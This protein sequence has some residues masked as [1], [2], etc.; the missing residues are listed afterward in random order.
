MA[1]AV[2]LGLAVALTGCSVSS[3][4][5]AAQGFMEGSQWTPAA[6]PVA[7]TWDELPGCPGALEGEVDVWTRV[8]GFPEQQIDAVGI[9][10]ECGDTWVDQPDGDNFVSIVATVRDTDVY[11]LDS[12]LTLAGYALEWD[13]FTTPTDTTIEGY[14][15][16]RDYY[17]ADGETVFTI[18][19]Y[20]APFVS[21]LY[22]V[23]LD[24]H[25]PATR[26][27]GGSPAGDLGL[28]TGPTSGRAAHSDSADKWVPD[29]DGDAGSSVSGFVPVTVK[30]PVDW[31]HLAPC[32]DGSGGTAWV[33]VSSFPSEIV[34]ESGI[35][36]FCGDTFVTDDGDSFVS[37]VATITEEQIYSLGGKLIAAGYT[38]AGDDITTSAYGGSG[39]FIG[40]RAYTLGDN[41]IV[42]N[43]WDNG[44]RP[45]SLTVFLDYYSAET[46]ALA[47]TT[48]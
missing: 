6:V 4:V 13:D 31:Q 8:D 14:A 18:E 47:D 34:D 46:R 10:A 48:P 22:T 26:V 11:L 20:E 35:H 32:D 24:F 15:G 27:P 40:G 30:G 29:G 33:L 12:E 42:I 1:L 25:S 36:P 41:A 3:G 28:G 39:A 37:A 9:L 45:L 17:L 16:A 7:N 23:Y 5:R 2:G 44:V 21:G 43:A 19:A 38:F